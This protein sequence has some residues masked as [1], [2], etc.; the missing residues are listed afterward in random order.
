MIAEFESVY[1]LLDLPEEADGNRVRSAYAERRAALEKQ[2]AAAGSRPERMMAAKALGDLNAREPETERLACA[3]EVSRFLA[4]AAEALDARKV[5]KTKRALG[6]A[7]GA[8]EKAGL[9]RLLDAVTEGEDNLADSGLVR[10]TALDAAIDE[11]AGQV[12]AREASLTAMVSGATPPPAD[13]AATAASLE[14]KCASMLARLGA[15]RDEEARERVQELVEKAGA[16]RAQFETWQA[17]RAAREYA[18]RL[19][20]LRERVDAS[21]APAVLEKIAVEALC[22]GVAEI[23]LALAEPP[24]AAGG[25]DADVTRERAALEKKLGELRAWLPRREA[26]TALE[27]LETQVAAPQ[28]PA[29]FGAEIDAVEK[30]CATA[31]VADA[32]ARIARVREAFAKRKAPPAPPPRPPPPP[33]LPPEKLPKADRGGIKPGIAPPSPPA[34]LPAEEVAPDLDVT[35]RSI[36]PA[37]PKVFAARK[38]TLLGPRGEHCHI[39]CADPVVFGRASTADI[40]VRAF[41]PKNPRERDRVT[42]AISRAHFTILKE[43]PEILL[44]DGAPLP[45]GGWQASVNG[46]F[47]ND[48]KPIKRLPINTPAASRFHITQEVAPA[49]PPRWEV[50]LQAKSKLPEM[51]ARLRDSNPPGPDALLLRRIDGSNDEVLIVWRAAN[52]RDLNLT[53]GDA[54][55]IRHQEGFVLWQDQRIVELET[56]FRVGGTWQV[57]KMGEL[58]LP[59]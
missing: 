55:L 43:G 13:F 29:N 18:G 12:A 40:V 48:G 31:T 50:H 22:D 33:P 35:V 56:G 59:K 30:Q 1:R 23:D 2:K 26:M 49:I 27:R 21:L 4:E 52:L 19:R 3:L 41:H 58:T 20:T 51:A 36:P 42:R 45:D 37:A 44:C 17:G 28:L 24:P 15:A 16:S 11:L 32:T 47:D 9:Q 53:T 38:F 25:A 34:K 46:T 57:A 8:A 7:R 39:I 54:A 6:N 10:D 5:A 14:A